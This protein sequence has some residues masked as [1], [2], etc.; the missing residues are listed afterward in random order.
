MI[1]HYSDVINEGDVIAVGDIHGRYD[2]F[3]EVLDWAEGSGAHLILLGD[4]IDRGPDDLNVLRES[5]KLLEDPS[6]LGLEGFTVLRGNH[7]QMLLNAVEGY[8]WESWV[9]NGGDWENFQKIKEHA[10]WIHELPLY[11]TFGSTM[12][13]HAGCVPGQNPAK[14]MVS[15][16]L[17]EEFVWM[18]EPFLTLG[19]QF[20]KWTDTLKLI[21]FG[22]TP[23][24]PLPYQIPNGIC[25]DTGAFRTG[26]L[27]T[28]NAT[29]DTFNQFE[30]E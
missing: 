23:K 1:F 7:E 4:L 18:R 27:T 16:H 10:G 30:I 22:H 17:R 14:S 9:R 5:Q 28:Y 20:E 11:V 15:N 8:G 21:V 24:S 12:F 6:V 25:I 29:Q 19:P 13:A 3:R 2:L 26:M